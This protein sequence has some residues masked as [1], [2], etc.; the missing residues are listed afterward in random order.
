M[1]PAVDYSATTMT[2][3]GKSERAMPV[4][5]PPPTLRVFPPSIH[6]DVDEAGELYGETIT[7]KTGAITRASQEGTLV[8]LQSEL[9]SLFLAI[10]RFISPT[11][12]SAH[13][14]LS[15]DMA[16]KAWSKLD[17]IVVHQRKMTV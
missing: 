12:P 14:H 11:N 16:A 17:R 13:V 4:L 7:I 1:A 15:T 6:F 10:I 9:R 8:G 2:R 3:T 5:P